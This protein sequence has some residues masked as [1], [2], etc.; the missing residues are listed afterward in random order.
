VIELVVRMARENSGWRYDRIAGA[1]KNLGHC[2][3]DQ[4]VG[5]LL[6]HLASRHRRNVVSKRLGR[7]S[8]DLT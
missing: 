8:F 6:R 2:V 4:T 5:N 7:S 3:S 1:L